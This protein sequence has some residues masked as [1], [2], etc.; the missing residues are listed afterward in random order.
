MIIMSKLFDELK[1][2]VARMN[3]SKEK[4][5]K[6]RE[7]EHKRRIEEIEKRFRKDKYWKDL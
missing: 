4:R 3:P 7:K 1:E 2:F 5:D 6:A